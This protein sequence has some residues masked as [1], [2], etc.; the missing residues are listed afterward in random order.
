MPQQAELPPI[1][2][3]LEI[4]EEATVEVSKWFDVEAAIE[5]ELALS[6]ALQAA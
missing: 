4:L 5:Q 6:P 1:T 2:E 3:I